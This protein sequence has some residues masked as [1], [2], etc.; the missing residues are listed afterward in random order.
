M[1]IYENSNR[2]EYHS[3]VGD[4]ESFDGLGTRNIR[5]FGKSENMYIAAFNKINIDFY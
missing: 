1:T 2:L 3:K 4:L 5:E